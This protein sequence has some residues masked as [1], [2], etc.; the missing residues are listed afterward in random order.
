MQTLLLLHWS[1]S[2]VCDN[3]EVHAAA[4]TLWKNT[5]WQY[6]VTYLYSVKM[7]IR[8]GAMPLVL[9][10][11]MSPLLRETEINFSINELSMA[12]KAK[13]FG[14]NLHKH[15]ERYYSRSVWNTNALKPQKLL[16]Q[17][18]WNFQN[19]STK[20]TPGKNIYVPLACVFLGPIFGVWDLSYRKQQ[21][22][23]FPVCNDK[24]TAP[25]TTG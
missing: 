25:C 8:A 3:R 5:A 23:I 17:K 11:E 15:F 7:G 4:W 1:Q 13:R 24:G 16:W 19:S 21:K 20:E 9:Q 18:A 6:L 10:R 22:C 12:R 14:D 2:T